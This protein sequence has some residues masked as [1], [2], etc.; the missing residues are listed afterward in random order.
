MELLVPLIAFLAVLVVTLAMVLRHDRASQQQIV[1][2][3]ISAPSSEGLE[4][5]EITRPTRARESAFMDQLLSKVRPIRRLEESLWQAGLYVR[6]S[7]VLALML[8][9]GLA[10][11]A[12]GAVWSG[13]LNFAAAMWGVGLALLPLV[14]V[15]WRKRRRLRAFDQQLPEILDLLKS[16]LEAG[17]TL[18]RA[19]QVTVEE[20]SEP[21]AGELRIVLEQNRLGVPLARALEYMLRRM[22]DEN[23]RFLVV[24]VKIQTDVGSSLAGIIA[25]LARTIRDRQRVEMRVRVLTAQ[26]RFGAI[27]GGL[28]P[29][30][31]LIGLHFIH[32]ETVTMLFHDPAGIKLTKGAAVLEALGLITIYSMVRVDY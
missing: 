11:V 12:A 30:V 26:P 15:R 22:P 10:G 21:A 20:F 5:V 3:R 13:G 14:Y 8:V 23:L 24:A 4:E 32:P 1:L 27:V 29:I 31:L 9:L 7:D 25:Q 2:S 19:L 17:H 16:S 18:Q 28:M 6:V